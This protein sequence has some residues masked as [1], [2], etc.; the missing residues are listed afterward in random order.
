ME[1]SDQAKLSLEII[2]KQIEVIVSQLEREDMP[3]EESLKMFEKGIR[4]CRW[5][6]VRLDE[7]EGIIEQLLRDPET[8]KEEI[9]PWRDLEQP[10][11][12]IE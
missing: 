7:A 9:L 6:S 3:L 4:Y 1:S 10:Q 5:A 8:G 12:D 2:L 11:D